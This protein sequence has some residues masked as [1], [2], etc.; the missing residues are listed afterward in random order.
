MSLAVQCHLYTK[1]PQLREGK[2]V[3]PRPQSSLGAEAGSRQLCRAPKSVL[4]LDM[5]AEGGEVRSFRRD[6]V[7][8]SWW[9]RPVIEVVRNRQ[10]KKTIPSRPITCTLS[11]THT[12][13]KP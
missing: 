8:S 3:C 5:P 13:W 9:C 11:V 4:V 2:N 12:T 10:E 6:C 7:S 1:K